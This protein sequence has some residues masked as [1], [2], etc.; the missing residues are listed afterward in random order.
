MKAKYFSSQGPDERTEI[1]LE[2][3]SSRSLRNIGFN[4]LTLCGMYL[5]SLI[6]NMLGIQ[7]KTIFLRIACHDNV[8][9]SE[10]WQMGK[11]C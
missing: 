10:S 7:S 4:R 2:N 11:Q 1:V 9:T 6:Q 8:S 5:K 3:K